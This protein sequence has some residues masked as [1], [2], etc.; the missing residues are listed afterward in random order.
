MVIHRLPKA[1]ID[2]HEKTALVKAYQQL[3]GGLN[4]LGC[5]TQPE[6]TAVFSLLSRHLT[7]PSCSPLDSARC[8]L[9]WLKG[10]IDQGIRFTQ[11]G[12]CTEGLT[13]WPDRRPE[14][15]PLSIVFTDANW[16]PQDAS[17]EPVWLSC[18]SLLIFITM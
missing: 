14:N 10:T 15:D 4:W 11:G 5:S 12:S 8:V 17:R 2:P 3:V 9:S 7:D 18:P 1:G 6:I 13:A 16:G